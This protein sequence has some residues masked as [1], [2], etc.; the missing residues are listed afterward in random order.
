MSRIRQHTVLGQ[1]VLVI[2]HSSNKRY[3][4][5][6]ICSHDRVH[7]D[8]IQAEFLYDVFNLHDTAYNNADIICV[9]EAQFFDDLKRF[10]EH[11]VECD[12]K[13]VIVCGLDGDY[14]RRPYRQL[15]DLIALADTVEKRNALC[16]KCRDGT[17]AS[18]SKR[19]VES[20]ER[21]LVGSDDAYI[22]VCRYHYN[23]A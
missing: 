11:A 16:I 12:K 6:G 23:V 21:H 14:Q 18:F 13:H 1:N 2:N 17:L 4:A 19:T 7:M 9:E 20:T 22:P 15:I 10:V 5:T 8:A 3:N